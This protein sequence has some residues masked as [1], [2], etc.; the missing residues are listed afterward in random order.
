M[1]SLSTSWNSFRHRTG[2]GLVEEVKKIGFDTIEL[3]FAL[4][5]GMVDEVLALS[6]R[7]E[8]KVSSLHNMCPLPPG[9]GPDEA[10]PDYY[11]LASPDEK[12]RALASARSENLELE[13]ENAQI[14]RDIQE[15]QAQESRARQE[16]RQLQQ[17]LHYQCYMMLMPM[18]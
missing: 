8:I 12:E 13:R 3:N 14:D 4:T 5:E 18:Q 11:S 16:A 9:V 7:S 1:F 10:S 17:E 6:R 2:S 15:R